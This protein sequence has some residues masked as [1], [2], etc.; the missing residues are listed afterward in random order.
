MIRAATLL[1]A[2]LQAAPAECKRSDFET[3][4]EFVDCQTKQLPPEPA[5]QASPKEQARSSPPPPP[6]PRLSPTRQRKFDEFAAKRDKAYKGYVGM[7]G[8]GVAVGTVGLVTTIVGL[9]MREDVA[10][11]DDGG[12][13]CTVGKRCGDACIEV[14]DTCHVGG[15]GGSLG[16]ITPTGKRVAI[17][18]SGVLIAGIGFLIGA[19]LFKREV[20]YLEWE[21]DRI[22]F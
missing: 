15:G 19:A 22:R 4:D 2:L 1:L 21:M 5:D 18:G 20:D 16:P 6:R 7:L 3:F 8:T 14:T 17:A 10:R 13:V 9:F 11:T 12:P